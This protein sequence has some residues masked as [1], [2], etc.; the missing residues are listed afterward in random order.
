MLKSI[1]KK[2]SNYHKSSSK[3]NIFI[4]T[5]PRSGSTWLMELIVTQR[6]FKYF[7]E[8]FNIRLLEVQNELGIESWEELYS[9][10]NLPLIEAYIQK[11]VQ[12]RMGFFNPNPFGDYYRPFTNRLV[13]KIIHFGEH[14]MNWFRDKF[15]GKIIYLVRHPMAV[16]ISRKQLPRLN[17]FLKSDYQNWMSKQQIRYAYEIIE[18]GTFLEKATLSWCLQNSISLH[19]KQD[20]WIMLTYEQ[21]VREPELIV[22][23]LSERLDFEQSDKILKNIEKQS[24]VKG[25]SDQTTHR[26]FKENKRD[27]LVSKWRKK[28][29]LE[30]ERR[31]WDIIDFFEIDIYSYNQ[32]MPND[33]YL[34]KL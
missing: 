21:M 32:Y 2:Y 5:M 6:G 23:Y 3:S 25:L 9:N 18:K 30:E 12:G 34:L 22:K 27:E 31:A 28:V 4:F 24:M 14:R 20:D 26:F 33:K 17:T 8:P 15:N 1:V 16:S 19:H 11:A 7:S 10:Q 29:S 13:F